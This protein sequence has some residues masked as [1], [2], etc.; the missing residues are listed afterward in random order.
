[1]FHQEDYYGSKSA[2]GTW[3]GMV[4]LV[5]NGGA[6]IGVSETFV[7]KERSEVVAFTDTLRFVR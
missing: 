2:N 4:A 6:D 3:N 5:K 1:V 7:T